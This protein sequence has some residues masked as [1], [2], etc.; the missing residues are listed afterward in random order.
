MLTSPSSGAQTYFFPLFFADEASDE[1]FEASALAELELS[2]LEE[3][4]DFE[5]SSD[6]DLLSFFDEESPFEEEEEGAED[7]LA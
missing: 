7:F 4:S 2:D 1:A 5:E 3:F 6:F